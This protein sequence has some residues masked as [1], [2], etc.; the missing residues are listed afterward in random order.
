MHTDF[1]L[2]RYLVAR[3]WDVDA[4]RDMFETAMKWREDNVRRV[5]M[6]LKSNLS[7]Y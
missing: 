2:A 7:G 1:Y 6:R 4:A 3:N 5:L